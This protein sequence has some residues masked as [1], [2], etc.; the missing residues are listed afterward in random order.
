MR[1]VTFSEFGGG[2][3][4]DMFVNAPAQIPGTPM[5]EA[6]KTAIA[7]REKFTKPLYVWCDY[8]VQHMYSQI[9]MQGFRMANIPFVAAIPVLSN[10]LS[11][12]ENNCTIEYCTKRNILLHNLK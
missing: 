5:Q 1:G 4:V 10:D 3:N 6:V 8:S 7:I 2:Q 11:K 9:A 12:R